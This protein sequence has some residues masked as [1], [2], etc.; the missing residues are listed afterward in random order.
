MR[1]QRGEFLRIRDGS[2]ESLIAKHVLLSVCGQ[3]PVTASFR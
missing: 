3:S 1:E 2:Q